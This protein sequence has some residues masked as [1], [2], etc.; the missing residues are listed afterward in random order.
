M[1]GYEPIYTA[2][3]NVSIECADIDGKVI[4]R[5]QRLVKYR[6][7]WFVDEDLSSYVYWKP[8]HWRPDSV[9]Q[10]TAARP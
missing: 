6:G 3:E 2:P 8:T 10:P 1:N 7:L 9:R 4:K 5:E